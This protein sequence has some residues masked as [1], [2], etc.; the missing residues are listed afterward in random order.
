MEVGRGLSV[1]RMTI[2]IY[3]GIFMWNPSCKIICHRGDL[4]KKWE[5]RERPRGYLSENKRGG[6]PAFVFVF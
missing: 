4:V 2:Y 3:I 5:H 1:S 6:A